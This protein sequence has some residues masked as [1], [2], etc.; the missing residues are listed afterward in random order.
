MMGFDH[1]NFDVAQVE[2]TLKKRDGS[3][4][5]PR[6]FIV[7]KYQEKFGLKFDLLSFKWISPW[8]FLALE[9]DGPKGSNEW[10]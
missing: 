5:F 8:G 2:I 4:L 7:R 3:V 1:V 9:T 6:V 10:M